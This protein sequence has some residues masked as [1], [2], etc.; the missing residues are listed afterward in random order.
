[1]K[2]LEGKILIFTKCFLPEK[3]ANQLPA[4]G[5]DPKHNTFCAKVLLLAETFL[6]SQSECL[7]G[8]KDLLWFLSIGLASSG[9][10]HLQ[11]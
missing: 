7:K 2:I 3:S 5:T 9:H 4:Q 6:N 10:K 8:A 1:M 11:S